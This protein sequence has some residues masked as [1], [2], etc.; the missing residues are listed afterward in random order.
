[1][2]NDVEIVRDGRRL[3]T[4]RTVSL[5]DKR[6]NDLWIPPRGNAARPARKELNRV[7]GGW[8]LRPHFFRAGKCLRNPSVR[9]AHATDCVDSQG[10]K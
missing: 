1:M 3:Q 6:E 8:G 10:L 4:A 2:K 5:Q 9:R 7:G